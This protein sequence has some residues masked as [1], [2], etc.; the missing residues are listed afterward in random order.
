MLYFYIIFLFLQVRT[1]QRVLFAFPALAQMISLFAFCFPFLCTCHILVPLQSSPS[2]TGLAPYEQISLANSL[3]LFLSVIIP[4]IEL[5]TH[6]HCKSSVTG[7]ICFSLS[8][9]QNIPLDNTKFKNYK[10]IRPSLFSLRHALS[11]Q[12]LVPVGLLQYSH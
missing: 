6:I 8:P 2:Y 10:Y 11:D 12:S 1:R 9:S 7:D 4:Y 5:F 3:S